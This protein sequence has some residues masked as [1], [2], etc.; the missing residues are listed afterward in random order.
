MPR[1]AQA[2][3]VRFDGSADTTS[4]DHYSSSRS[5][6]VG[7]GRY[8]RHMRGWS[9]ATRQESRWVRTGY[10]AG[11]LSRPGI[12]RP[13]GSIPGVYCNEQAEGGCAE[14]V[15]VDLVVKTACCCSANADAGVAAQQHPQAPGER[16][17]GTKLTGC[18][19]A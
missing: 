18:R 5:S 7:D 9:W 14:S 16:A 6:S 12:H 11:A 15:A 17:P 19:R 13:S 10:T 3:T 1:M 4:L 8:A 2:P